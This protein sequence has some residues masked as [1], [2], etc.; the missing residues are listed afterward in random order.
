VIAKESRSRYQKIAQQ[1]LRFISALSQN[2]VIA[3]E[4]LGPRDMHAAC[5]SSQHGRAL[6]LGKIMS[7]ANSQMSEDAAQ[8][9]LV[10]LWFLRLFDGPLDAD[11]LNEP[12]GEIAYRENEIRHPGRYRAARHGRVFSLLGVLHEND[13]ARLVNGTHADGRI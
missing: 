11:E 9:L 5:D 10:N 4:V 7:G 1:G 12:C 3:R 8:K 2:F 13:A 6:V